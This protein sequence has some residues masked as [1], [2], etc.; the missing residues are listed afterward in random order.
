[1]TFSFQEE[2]KDAREGHTRG[3]LVYGRVVQGQTNSAALVCM[4]VSWSHL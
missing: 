1:M 3:P 2:G 4:T